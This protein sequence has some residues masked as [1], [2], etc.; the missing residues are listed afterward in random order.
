MCLQVAQLSINVT[1]LVY[2]VRIT[3]AC[4]YLLTTADASAC[5]APVPGQV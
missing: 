1:S 2:A 3:A 5:A 4:L